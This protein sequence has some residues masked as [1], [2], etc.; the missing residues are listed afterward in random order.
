MLAR[1]KGWKQRLRRFPLG[2]VAVVVVGL[3]GL[4]VFKSVNFGAGLSH[5]DLH[6]LS[7]SPGG[8][9]ARVVDG[10]AARAARR[11]GTITSVPS[12]GS[13]D[14]LRRLAEGAS[15]CDVQFALVQDGVPIAD[16]DKLEVIGRLPRRETVFVIGKDAERLTR[17][18]ELRGMK[19]GVGPANSGADYL[20][21]TIFGADELKPLGLVLSNHDLP[22]QLEQLVGGGLDLGV[23][24]MDENAPL[25]RQAIR[26]RGLQ[27][28]SLEHLDTVPTRVP[29]MSL[30]T[31]EAGQY[32]P[33]AVIPGRDHTVLRV[34]TLVI[35]NKCA[36]RSAEIG[37]L[38]L[39]VEELPGYLAV[40][41]EFRGGAL[42]RSEV[43]K[44]FYAAEGPGFAD[45]YFPWLVNIMPLGNWFYIIMVV[46][47]LF[48]AM[49]LAH[50]VRLWRVDA[51]RDKAFQ[52]VRDALGEQLTPHEIMELEPSRKH[53]EAKAKIDEAIAKLDTLRAKT[54]RQENSPLVPLGAEWMYRYEEEQM[55]LL[56]TALR[57]F[58]AKFPEQGDG[59]KGDGE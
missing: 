3:L 17:F 37:L 59:E 42:R 57:A 8:N 24:V 43:A 53:L 11:G 28:A 51:N 23:F 58:R 29:V 30:G 19:I 16:T 14:N 15:S 50:K 56:L 54:R 2:G 22:A 10:L 41:K 44:E 6:V 25:I 1:M 52:I 39:L 4:I 45:Q 12:Q 46:S 48:N 36:K 21:R 47:V 38:D 32:D 55:E 35:G 20:G 33:L 27:L 7:G 49:T 9:Y 40:N 31:I 34:D 13:V 26:E 18:A 5:V